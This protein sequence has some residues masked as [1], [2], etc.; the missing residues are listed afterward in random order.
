[1]NFYVEPF[2]PKFRGDGFGNLADYRK[3]NK[4]RGQDWSPKAGSKVKAITDGTIFVN[5]W[6]DVLGWFVVQ[7]TLDGY[8]VLYAHLDKQSDLIVGVKVRA[9]KTVLGRTGNTGS[10]TTGSHLHLSMGKANKSWSNPQIH[11]AAYKDLIDPLKH[12]TENRK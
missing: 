6:S 10:A 3:G 2:A 12:I 5:T 1:M 8:F 7:S 9:G 11:L 4:H